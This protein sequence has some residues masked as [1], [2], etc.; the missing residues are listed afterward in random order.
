MMRWECRYSSCEMM[1]LDVQPK[2]VLC[3][4]DHSADRPERWSFESVLAG[5][6]DGFVESI[7]G[8]AVL[9]GL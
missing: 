4:L 5:E 1:Y 9:K 3:Y 6:H 7:F 8:R 2:E